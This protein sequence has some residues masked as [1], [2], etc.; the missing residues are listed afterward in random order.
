[1]KKTDDNKAAVGGSS[2]L[3]CSPRAVAEQIAEF[4]FTVGGPPPNAKATHLCLFD[5]GHKGKY[6]AGWGK[7]PATDAIERILLENTATMAGDEIALPSVP[8]SAPRISD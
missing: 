7:G 4:M 5:G 6:L 1:M 8:G 2:P 3:I